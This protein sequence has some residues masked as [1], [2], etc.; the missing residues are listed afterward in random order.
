M[1]TVSENIYTFFVFR[2]ACSLLQYPFNSSFCFVTIGVVMS[3]A[4]TGLFCP[5]LRLI[6]MSVTNSYL[7]A[8]V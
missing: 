4:V 8:W 1:K 2:P 7:L 3:L 6:V 5:V